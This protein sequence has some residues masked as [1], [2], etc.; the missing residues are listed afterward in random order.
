MSQKRAAEEDAAGDEPEKKTRF[1]DTI[2]D[3]E[4][5]R[6]Y[7]ERTELVRTRNRARVLARDIKKIVQTSDNAKLVDDLFSG[8]KLTPLFR[9]EDFDPLWVDDQVDL[10]DVKNAVKERILHEMVEAQKRVSV[11]SDVDQ[12]MVKCYQYLTN[13]AEQK[14]NLDPGPAQQEAREFGLP[15][16]ADFLPKLPVLLKETEDFY[17][18][19]SKRQV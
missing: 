17:R 10:N 11:V 2:F 8:V 14:K 6:L 15:D 19:T 16:L 4:A 1:P 13:V 7:H 3:D 9:F 5:R 12:L 18:S